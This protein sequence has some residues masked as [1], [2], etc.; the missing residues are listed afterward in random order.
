MLIYEGVAPLD[1]AGPLQVFGVVNALCGR[2]IYDIVTVA[3]TP[4]PIPTRLGFALMPHRAFDGLEPVDT[5]LI[6][7]GADPDAGLT[8]QIVD[9]LRKQAA[10]TRRIGSI[11]TGSFLLGAAG[12]LEGKRA[13]THWA[14]TAELAKR[15]RNTIVE[16]D[17]IYIRDGNIYSS[18]GITAGID[19][20][21]ALVEEDH[22]LDLA[23]RA[24]RYLVLFLKRSSSQEQF[25]IR[26]RAQFST[27]PAI[28]RVQLWCQDNLANDLCVPVL[29]KRAGMSERSFIRKF[30]N[31][32]G[33]TPAE[34]VTS[35]RLDA[36]CRLLEDTALPI[37]TI[38]QR[39]GF[40]SQTTM[41]RLYLRSLGVSPRQYRQ[42]FRLNAELSSLAGPPVE[43]R[44]SQSASQG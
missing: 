29:A 21:L 8:P 2:K 19:L 34:F 42:K 11:C 24:A 41:Q 43:L 12:L 31:D 39:C 26:L 17:P 4:D 13:T 9:W 23:L 10:R 15:H 14:F 33:Y 25:S 40:G 22:G 32:T 28:Q 6:S 20:A 5:L 18:A 30:Q 37:K 3:P 27:V 38:A 7:G 44:L 16:V 36:A 35:V 1:V